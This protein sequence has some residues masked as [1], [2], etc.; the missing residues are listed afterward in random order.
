[1]KKELNK[2]LKLR[3]SDIN[4][5]LVNS[6]FKKHTVDMVLDNSNY[7]EEIIKRSFEILKEDTIDYLKLIA[8]N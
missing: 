5:I 6:Q 8:R 1:M 4:V 7:S 2:Y 3:N